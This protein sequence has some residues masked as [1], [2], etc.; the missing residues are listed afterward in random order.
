MYN[1]SE[2]TNQILQGH[3][4]EVLKKIP[5]NSIDTIIT[6]PPYHGLRDYGAEVMTIWDGDKNCEH[7][8]ELEEKKDPNFRG[9]S[10]QF[11]KGGVGAE[12]DTTRVR[13]EGFCKKCGAWYGQ[14]GLEPTL[15]LF[16]EHT[17]QITAELKRVLKETGVMFWNM[18]DCYNPDKCLV[19][20][21]YRL[22]IKM[23]DEQGFILRNV[24]QWYKPNHMPTSVQDRFANSHEPV[25]MFVKSQRYFFDLDAV[26]IPSISN[27]YVQGSEFEQKYGT[28]F[29]RFGKNTKKSQKFITPEQQE[30]TQQ[31]TG[32]ISGS[33]RIRS[34][35]DNSPN[36][37]NPAGKNPGDIWKISTQAFSEAHFATFPEKLLER[38]I[39]SS[40]PKEICK[41]CG[42]IRK[43][44]IKI[45]HNNPK[46]TQEQYK[47]VSK[48]KES[49]TEHQNYKL[50]A[51]L[52]IKGNVFAQHETLGWTK[53]DCEP[54]E[55]KKGIVLDPFCGSATTCVVARKLNRNFIGIEISK[56]YIEIA[57]Q[58]LKGQLEPLF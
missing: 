3:T 14:L 29:D 38:P 23:I 34:F 27:K 31:R 53:C 52:K 50:T 37:S 58:R 6:S 49:I 35:F 39:M 42:F 41:K 33:G 12:M 45:H 11:D 10:G 36:V 32:C 15:D 5:D 1:I 22:T 4:L 56:K 55:Y 20:Q 47:E 48:N 26:R 9:G 30:E 46:Q 25:Y 44:I 8:W 2:I 51:G 57:K 28:P 17:L 19:M 24:I 18:G 21:N 7:E 16:L 54:Q 43:R 40:C 13:K